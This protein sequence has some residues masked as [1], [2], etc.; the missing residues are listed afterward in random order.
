[1]STKLV[2]PKNIEIPITPT[3]LLLSRA[4]REIDRANK[5]F[6]NINMP[7]TVPQWGILFSSKSIMIQCFKE[8]K[9]LPTA[10]FSFDLS[11]H[12]FRIYGYQEKFDTADIKMKCELRPAFLL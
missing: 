1:M 4:E 11:S 3:V 9:K 12:G 6:W 10:Y 8:D 5:N 7:T 2:L